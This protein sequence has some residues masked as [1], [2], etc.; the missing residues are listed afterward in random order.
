MSTIG[1]PQSPLRKQR[2]TVAA[3]VKD[4]FFLLL[5]ASE[6][7]IIGLYDPDGKI[8]TCSWHD[9]IVLSREKIGYLVSLFFTN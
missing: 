7:S 3:K 2:I 4:L 1:E 9:E 6:T 8:N 5:R